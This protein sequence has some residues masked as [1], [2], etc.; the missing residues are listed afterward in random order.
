M[1]LLAGLLS[2]IAEGYRSYHTPGHKQGWGALAE[3][4]QLLG[5]EVFQM[6]LTELPG[7]I[8]SRITGIIGRAQQAA[9]GYFGAKETFFL[10]NG[11]TAGILAVLLA[12]SRPGS[13]VVLPRNSH[14]AVMPRH[15]SQRS[16]P[17]LSSGAGSYRAGLPGHITAT[18]LES[19]LP[20]LTRML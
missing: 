6:D 18:D 13:K 15:H 8:I 5:D 3:W 1:P 16:T 7:W 9:A 2:H 19:A 10:V 11:T 4:R 14:Q 17:C 20:H 12:K